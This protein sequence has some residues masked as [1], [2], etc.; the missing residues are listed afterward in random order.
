MV[1]ASSAATWSGT[2]ISPRNAKSIPGSSSRSAS[3]QRRAAG[4]TSRTRRSRSSA[5]RPGP[6]R[7]AAPRS[8]ASSTAA[9]IAARPVEVR[10]PG[11]GQ[12]DPTGGAAQ[13]GDPELGL[14]LA[15]LLGQRR[16]GHVQALG[17]P[18]E[19]P[20]LGDRDEVAQVT[21]LHTIHTLRVSIRRNGYFSIWTAPPTVDAWERR[22]DLRAAPDPGGA[23][24]RRP[25]LADAPPTSPSL[26]LTELVRRTGLGEGD[27]DDVVLGQGYANGE[28]PAIGRIAALD[29]GLG[30]RRARRPDRPPL[31]V[32]AAGRAVRRRRRSR[33]APRGSS[34][35]A[36][37][38]RCRRSSTTPS[39]CAPAS[40]PAASS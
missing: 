7:R 14:E 24:R 32:R 35:P 10:R 9:R 17:G 38:S 13:Q 12:V 40:A 34:W 26:T 15:H 11:V 19:V 33:P 28:S 27:V 21:Q 29:A 39:A 5:D 18:A 31:R 1:P 30:H 6:G 20:L 37:P 23:L 36:G 4:C 16:L 22:R 8:P 3:R 25:R 2:S